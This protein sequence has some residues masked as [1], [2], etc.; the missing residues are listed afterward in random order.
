MSPFYELIKASKPEVQFAEFL[1]ENKSHLLWWYKNG[2]KG[3][4][5]FAIAYKNYQGVESLFYV[6]F[7]IHTQSGVTCLFD[8]KTAG[9]DGLNAHLKH[10]A[11][12][13]FIAKRNQKGLKTIGGVLISKENNGVITWRY[14]SNKITNTNDL[15]GWEFFSPS[16][17]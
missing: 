7:I 4:E 13:D 8:T 15:T 12:I 6:D 17:I 9:S 3:K 2:D 5:H 10:N 11:L 16:T 14:C 1:E